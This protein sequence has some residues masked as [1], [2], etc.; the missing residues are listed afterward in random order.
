[1]GAATARSARGSRLEGFEGLRAIAAFGVFAFHLLHMSYVPEWNWVLREIAGDL[2]AGV[3]VFFLIS[4]FLLYLPFARAHAGS[5]PPVETRGFLVRRVLR[6][7]PAYWLALAG[8]LLFLIPEARFKS[9]GEGVSHVLLLHSYWG[10]RVLFGARGVGQSWTLVIELSFYL[11][12]PVYAWAL[13]RAATRWGTDRAEVVALGGLAVVGLVS[14]AVVVWGHPQPWLDVLPSYLLYFAMGM[15]LAV[16]RVGVER[17][18]PWSGRWVG[19]MANVGRWWSFAAVAF[20]AGALLPGPLSA[21]TP[22]WSPYVLHV[23]Q[24]VLAF[25]IVAPFTVPDAPPHPIR[26]L[27]TSRPMELLGLISYGIY[28]WHPALMNYIRN[29]FG[30][31][32]HGTLLV[33][34]SLALPATIGIAWLSY[35]LVEVPAMRWSRRVPSRS[36]VRLRREHVRGADGGRC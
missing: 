17:D 20:V 31:E 3:V 27:V 30:V 28:L 34:A 15:G 21:T 8:S 18:A 36:T 13:L 2:N 14:R 29:S 22:S 32:A 33:V 16:A 5:V 25:A 24:G 1:M 4:G 11:F 9:F 12:L 10:E 26:R 6:I 7:F 19:T 35:R 23:V